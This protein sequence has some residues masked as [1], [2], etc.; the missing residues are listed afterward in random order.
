MRLSEE[1]S[2][3]ASVQTPVQG[4]TS[5]YHSHGPSCEGLSFVSEQCKGMLAS[6]LD[7]DHGPLEEGGVCDALGNILWHILPT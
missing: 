5:Q 7:L 2:L 3:G 1:D 6:D 4:L